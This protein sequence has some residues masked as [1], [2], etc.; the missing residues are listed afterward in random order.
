MPANLAIKGSET[1]FIIC[2]HP[3]SSVITCAVW[4]N[5]G[6]CPHIYSSMLLYP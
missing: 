6:Q 1:F 5:G 4:A 3:A 2:L